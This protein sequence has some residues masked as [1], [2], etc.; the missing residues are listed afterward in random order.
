MKEQYEMITSIHIYS[1]SPCRLQ[2]L[3]TLTETGR[4]LFNSIF[5]K[6]DPLLHNKTYGVIQNPG[7][8]RRT[9]KRPPI[10][11]APIAKL[12]LGKDD[13]RQ[14]TETAATLRTSHPPA[15]LKKEDSSRPSS[16]G[17]STT[18]SSIKQPTLR[19]DTSDIFKSFA[20]AKS[21]PQNENKDID[22]SINRGS[23]AQSGPENTNVADADEEGE[24]ED[25][26][27]FLD[28]N[29]RR[30]A[31]KRPGE[32][33]SMAKDRHERAA[34][35]RKMMD[36]DEE[37][38]SESAKTGEKKEK[39]DTTEAEDA[40]VAWSESDSEQVEAAKQDRASVDKEATATRAEPMRRRGR[41]K[42]M[43]K[44]TMKD[45]EG[46]LVTK[47][48]AVWESFSEE[49]PASQPKSRTAFPAKTQSQHKSSTG[50]AKTSMK[51]PGKGGNIMSFFGK[52]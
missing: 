37:S 15:T 32:E 34:K 29:T 4:Y 17:S 41:R 20:K 31:K 8:R 14:P 19:R 27:L 5:V 30:P 10:L 44:R 47:E 6:E 23:P 9:G 28:T 1:L 38:E 12:T 33:G 35:L 52:K 50:S 26:A 43:K 22:A 13:T 39:A 46:Y 51:V 7:V 2:D 49:E 24:S 25:E 21:K 18:A 42:V 48:E 45:E 16:A 11:E 36:S 40:D 3:Q